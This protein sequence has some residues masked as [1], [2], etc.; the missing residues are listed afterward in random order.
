MTVGDHPCFHAA[1]KHLEELRNAA[2]QWTM[3][4]PQ[5]PPQ[6]L[7]DRNGFPLSPRANVAYRFRGQIENAIY[8][9][10]TLRD[11]I[12]V[13]AR[14]ETRLFLRLNLTLFPSVAN[15]VIF[16]LLQK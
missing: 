11:Q 16:S 5:G 9:L 1:R 3:S 7:K 8:D 10:T 6:E 12:G 4:G 14:H 2:R 15:L 13:M